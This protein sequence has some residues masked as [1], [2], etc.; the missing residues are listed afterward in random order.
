MEASHD[1]KVAIHYIVKVGNH[2][3]KSY[4]NFSH[5]LEHRERIEFTLTSKEDQAQRFYIESDSD[6]EYVDREE[7]DLNRKG[8]IAI[9][10]EIGGKIIR[11]TKKVTTAIEY[12][13]MEIVAIGNEIRLNAVH[14]FDKS[15]E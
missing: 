1:T 7:E 3:L 8:L 12:S 5:R 6:I 15:K 4:D 13:E 2:F 10:D 9:A 14:L 11:I